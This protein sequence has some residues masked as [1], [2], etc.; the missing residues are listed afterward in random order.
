M[1]VGSGTWL[2]AATSLERPS[3][4]THR[5]PGVR[6]TAR[7]GHS[8]VVG[9]AE[10]LLLA[11]Q[12]ELLMVGADDV[13]RSDHVALRFGGRWPDVDPRAPEFAPTAPYGSQKRVSIPSEMTSSL[14]FLLGAYVSEGHTA[15]SNWTVTI[16]NAVDEVLE[17][18]AG[19]IRA[20]FDTEPRM[21]RPRNRCPSVVLASKTVV[22]FLSELGCGR[23][24]GEK[25]IPEWVMR[26]SPETVVAFLE[27][28]F[29]DAFTAWMG[30]TP[31][32]GIS[33]ASPGLL[34]D[35]QIVL[36]RLGILHGR[37]EKPDASTGRR[38]GEVYAVG[39]AAQKL[40][41]LV[42]FAEPDKALRAQQRLGV[43]PSQSTAD[44]VPIVRP[45]A[46]HAVLPR[47]G[48]GHGPRT[49]YAFLR[50]PRS[51]H[52]S[53]RTLERLHAEPG[54][55]LPAEL[56]WVLGNGIHFSPV[57]E[58]LHLPGIRLHDCVVGDHETLNGFVLRACVEPA[59]SLR[60]IG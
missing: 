11:R 40:L 59:R 53:R 5:G 26:S 9:R 49:R 60:R 15:P 4:T 58:V 27:G 35:V 6:I 51:R 42:P 1:L 13:R 22:E 34:D 28:L 48:A 41:R 7:S 37:S 38:Y 33:V 30:S 23:V 8:L 21:V 25:R 14:A 39:E 20:T 50:D 43:A 56:K 45:R 3:G 31:K 54:V 18:V 17:R 16:T 46:L 52:V 47:S 12:G 44:V 32:W 19:A 2:Q 10:E 57:A 36:T 24:A 29:L 55:N